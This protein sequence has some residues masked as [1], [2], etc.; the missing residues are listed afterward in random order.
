V[1]DGDFTPSTFVPVGTV[2]SRFLFGAGSGTGS[3]L[4]GTDGSAAGTTLIGDT[5]SWARLAAIGPRAMLLSVDDREL[6]RTDGTSVE[7]AGLGRIDPPQDA[8]A[9]DDGF[10]AAG[11]DDAHGAELWH[12]DE[13]GRNARLVNDIAPGRTG[14]APHWFKR[15]RAG[16][17]L[18]ERASADPA[19][20][21]AGPDGTVVKPMHWLRGR[22]AGPA[23]EVDGYAYLTMVSENRQLL[24]RTDG[25]ETGT[26]LLGT[27]S[28]DFDEPYGFTAF[29]GSVWFAAGDDEHGVELWRTDGTAAGTRLARDIN[30]G[31]WSSR[32]LDLVATGDFLFFSAYHP[33][34][35][36]EPWR[37][38]RAPVIDPPVTDPPDGDPPVTVEPIAPPAGPPPPTPPSSAPPPPRSLTTA[39]KLTVRVQRLR[40]LRGKARYRVSGRLDGTSCAGRVRIVLGRRDRLLRHI[41]APMK[42]CRFDV[43]VRTTSKGHGRW[44]QVRTASSPS[45]TSRRV[46]VR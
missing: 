10:L 31:E 36:A 42:R 21:I 43:V 22:S 35:G 28:Y 6:A 19:W 4:W 16:V 45:V 20:R 27:F 25:T 7:P 46:P 13:D 32:P 34:Y 9:V 12:L 1:F 44:L 37:I 5:V 18:R 26:T 41:T 15:V 38:R 17:L 3:Q 2:G 14:S 39:G 33:Q 8:V 30:P 40:A 23:T 29:A 11:F 24:Y